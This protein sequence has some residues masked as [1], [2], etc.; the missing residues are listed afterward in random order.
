MED[1]FPWLEVLEDLAKLTAAA[2]L[3]AYLLHRRGLRPVAVTTVTLAHVMAL[4]C[5]MPTPAE[6]AF[7]ATVTL[8][9]CT[10]A[11]LA[12]DRTGLRAA[13]VV[14]C[15][16]TFGGLCAQASPMLFMAAM[17]PLVLWTG[18]ML[19]IRDWARARPKSRPDLSEEL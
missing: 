9:I 14:A 13:I 18:F 11:V 2:S 12:V 8:G 5:V 17:A 3:F 4:F 7:A 19:T 15:F 16:L 6:F 10:Y 1:F